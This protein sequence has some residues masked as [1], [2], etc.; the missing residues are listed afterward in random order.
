MIVE[1]VVMSP[2]AVKLQILEGDTQSLI[3]E[4]D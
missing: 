2:L 3:L 4:L 1:L